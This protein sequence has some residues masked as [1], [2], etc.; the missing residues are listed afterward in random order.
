MQTV[1]DLFRL[2]AV[3]A[4]DTVLHCPDGNTTYG[5]LEREIWQVAAGLQAVGVGT[6]DRVGF[7]LPNLRAYLALFG[8]CGLL[9]AVAVAVNTRFRQTEIADILQRTR[10][11]VLAFVP[12]LGRTDH[13]AILDAVEPALRR[14]L[15]A[16]VQCGGEAPVDGVGVPVVAYRSLAGAGP[17]ASNLGRPESGCAIFST[18][19]TTSLPKF[20]LHGQERTVRHA[21]D[22]ARALGLETPGT[23]AMQSLPFCGVFGFAYLLATVHA[24]A[25]T[26]LPMTFDATRCATLV[27]KHAVTHVAGGDDML[28][29]LL[30]AGD[31][32]TGGAVYPFPTLRCCPYAMFNA[33]LAEFP[34][35]AYRR[36]LPL[37]GPFGMSEVFSFFSLRRP[38]DPRDIRF[39][40][41]GVPVNP[42]SRVRA[43][44]PE[45]GKLVG[46]DTEGELEMTGPNLFL[47]YFGDEAATAAAM[48]DDGFF[49]TGDLGVTHEDGSFTYLGRLGDVLRLGGF[50]VNPLEIETR[51]CAHPSVE[52]AQVVAAAT[53]RGNR[54]VGFVIPAC[55]Q[56]IEPVLL[57]EFCRQRLAGYKVPVTVIPVAGFPATESANGRKIRKGALR[58]MAEEAVAKMR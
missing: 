28:S 5:E 23:M 34:Q 16:L 40:G 8:A 50:L 41:G 38:D 46:H 15:R 3:K 37:V 11:K 36:G 55:D 51:L 21:C 13:L 45:S 24:G 52:D 26:V 4:P 29:R 39:L 57:I 56:A 30:E 10:P 6:G 20:V 32:M 27:Q 48:T 18:S 42:A 22:A 9:G 35:T 33:A 49:R 17:L 2:A 44:D 7:W 25:S 19:G 47:G 12:R 43:R 54:A 31:R 53:P 14:Q 58:R 1:A